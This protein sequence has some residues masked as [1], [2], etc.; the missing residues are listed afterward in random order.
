MP[1]ATVE[2]LVVLENTVD[3][4]GV[5]LIAYRHEIAHLFYASLWILNSICQGNTK[6]VAR[7]TFD[8][9]ANLLLK[10][11]EDSHVPVVAGYY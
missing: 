9:L 5:I 7:C 3:N 8:G 11:R 4:K 6:G 1:K 2:R 10:G